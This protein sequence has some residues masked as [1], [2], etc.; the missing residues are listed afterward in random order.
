MSGITFIIVT[1]DQAEAMALADRIA[2]LEGGRLRQVDTPR[3]LYNNPVDA[4]V[5]DFIGNVHSFDVTKIDLVVPEGLLPGVQTGRGRVLTIRPE[6]I[7]IK[8]GD[9]YVPGHLALRGTVGDIAFQGQ[10]SIV[11]VRVNESRSISAIVDDDTAKELDNLS[12]DAVIQAHWAVADM[13]LLESS[14]R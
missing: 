11:E 6:R 1:H 3:N 9:T 10:H 4:F 2:V 5:A 14:A 8:I 13:H 12:A 7:G